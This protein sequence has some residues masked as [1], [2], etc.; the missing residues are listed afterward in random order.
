M[1]R[2]NTSKTMPTVAYDRLYSVL[3]LAFIQQSLDRRFP[4]IGQTDLRTADR[5][6]G[7][8]RWLGRTQVARRTDDTDEA[9][10]IGRDFVAHLELA[11]RSEHLTV[12]VS[13]R[14][15]NGF[16]A[17]LRRELRARFIP[18][19]PTDQVPLLFWGH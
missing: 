18:A 11:L 8:L 6:L 19:T 17:S 5:S 7:D 1:F 3:D 15:D 2:R 9:L 10:I 16:V 4:M 12:A 13:T 14:S